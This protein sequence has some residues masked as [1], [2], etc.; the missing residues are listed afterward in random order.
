VL[1]CGV[2]GLVV[3][4]VNLFMLYNNLLWF[5]MLLLIIGGGVFG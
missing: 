1:V 4:F 2:F 3:G 5:A